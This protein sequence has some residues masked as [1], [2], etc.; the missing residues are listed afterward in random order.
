VVT[1]HPDLLGRHLIDAVRA[2]YQVFG[3]A[4]CS[5]ARTGAPFHPNIT[6][7]EVSL[8]D[9]DTLAAVFRRIRETGGADL[10][11]FLAAPPGT[12]PEDQEAARRI[13]VEGL[14]NVLEACRR[15]KPRRFVYA[16][17]APAEAAPE[18]PAPPSPPPEE[19]G[20]ASAGSGAGAEIAE[21]AGSAERARA[22]APATGSE[23]HRTA[24]AAEQ[25]TAER[26]REYQADFPSSRI[27]FAA[28]PRLVIVGASGFI[29]RHLVEAVK[30]DYQVIGLARTSQEACGVPVHPN[31]AWQQVDI[32]DRPA[33][34][35]AFRRIRGAGGADLVVHLAAY[36][37]FGGEDHPEYKRTNIEGLRNVLDECRSLRPRLFVFASSVAASEFPAPG[38]RLNEES[39]ADGSHPYAVTKRRGEAMLA[40]Y[41]GSFPSA[42]VRLGATYSDWCEYPPIFISLERWRSSAWDRRI[43][44]GRGLFAIPYIHVRDTQSF[45][46]RLLG[47]AGGIA[48]GEVLIASTDTPVA[49]RDLFQGVGQFY[50]GRKQELIYVPRLLCG[51]GMQLKDVAGRLTGE[52]PFERP[53]M[54]RYIDRAMPVDA[55]RTRQRLG[56]APRERF[57]LVRRL[58]FLFENQK[59][60]PV[61]WHRRNNAVMRRS[62]TALNLRVHRLLEKHEERIARELAALLQGGRGAGALGALHSLAPDE[63]HWSQKVAL[64]QLMSAIRTRDM[65][66]YLMFCR[67]LAE[68]RYA[69]GFMAAE[70]TAALRALGATCVRVL[71]EDPEA[72]PLGQELDDQITMTTLFGCDQVEE[73]FDQLTD[74]HVPRLPGGPAPAP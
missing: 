34:E 20:P 24:E 63:V 67:D 57:D 28:R 36:Y 12:A 45:F 42:V 37:D 65:A 73:T 44:G 56:W 27:Q 52:R 17:E 66:V 49:M 58:P 39:P 41:A 2:D 48:P 38:V 68:R 22:P 3:V 10:V 70:V 6:W 69:Q 16:S 8:A 23:D 54:A 43:L 14:K 31:V 30:E 21:G 64:H 61:E 25:A 40:E 9:G 59:S 7:F 62:R 72:A 35:A 55:S 4:G 33:L 29:G 50:F 32:C 18:Q 51:L 11:M 47:Q 19:P 1:G 74:A 71:S 46:R 60:N 13:N 26:L 15:L 5:Q 53:W